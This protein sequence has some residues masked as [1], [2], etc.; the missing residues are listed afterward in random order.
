MSNRSSTGGYTNGSARVSNVSTIA[1]TVDRTKRISTV[2]MDITQTQT[3]VLLSGQLLHLKH[4]LGSLGDPS[5][6]FHH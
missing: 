2:S 4:N 5:N 6:L 1:T 3:T